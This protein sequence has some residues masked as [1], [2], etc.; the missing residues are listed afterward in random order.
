MTMFDFVDDSNFVLYAA[1]HYDNPS[2]VDE[3]EFYDDLK[4]F[5]Y[6]KKLFTK[7]RQKNELRE[8]LIINHLIVIYNVFGNGATKMLFFKLDDY[9]EYLK[10]FLVFME[11][12]PETVDGIG[13][14]R[15]TITSTEIVMDYEIINRLRQVKENM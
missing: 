4:R 5:N 10:P 13:K 14:E 15:K 2:C 11:R 12:M 9:K 6:L 3:S 1:K 7:Y 8:R